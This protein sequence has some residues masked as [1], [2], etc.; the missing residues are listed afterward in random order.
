MTRTATD[1][2][3]VPAGAKPVECDR[4]RERMYWGQSGNGRW[5]MVDCSAPGASEPSESKDTKQLGIF[6]ATEVKDGAG[7]NHFIACPPREGG[8]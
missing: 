6:G 2:I 7:I 4:C 1:F 8:R 5:V 3:I